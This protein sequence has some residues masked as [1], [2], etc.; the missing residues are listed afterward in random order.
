MTE[1]RFL[2]CSYPEYVSE[3]PDFAFISIYDPLYKN[4][5]HWYHG[6]V[7]NDL[8]RFM[9]WSVLCES[10]CIFTVRN[11][12]C[13][14]VMFSQASVILSTE[15]GGVGGA[16]GGMCGKRC[17][18][19]RGMHGERG[20]ACVAKGGMHGGVGGACVA[21]EMATA[22]DGTHPTGMH[23]C[24]LNQFSLHALNFWVSCK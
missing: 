14:K 24:H 7:K 23:S 6:S 17:A 13:G 5:N 11:Y 10:I 9:N 1:W 18:W 8:S 12:C 21:G 3:Y 19:Q 2:R 20:G 22:V 16:K 4:P 15:G